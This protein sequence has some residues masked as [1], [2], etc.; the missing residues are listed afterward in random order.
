[1]HHEGKS[2][3]ELT[4]LAVE[5]TVG[6]QRPIAIRF[7]QDRSKEYW[8]GWALA[9]YQWETGLS[10]EELAAISGVSVRTIQEYEQRRKDINK[11]QLQTA[12]ALAQALNCDAEALLER[13]A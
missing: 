5:E 1:M 13:V 7:R 4:L 10:Q 3:A 12:M 8:V 2:G 6:L 9:H 11:A